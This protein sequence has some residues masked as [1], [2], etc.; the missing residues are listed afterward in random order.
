MKSNL[1]SIKPAVMKNSA[2]P[3]KSYVVQYKFDQN[4]D[5]IE[6]T[7]GSAKFFDLCP[8]DTHKLNKKNNIIDLKKITKIE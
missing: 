5:H 2:D 4:I 1:N 3:P 7:A 8:T 6:K